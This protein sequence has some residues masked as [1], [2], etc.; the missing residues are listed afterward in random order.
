MSGSLDTPIPEKVT[1]PV[2]GMT[3]AS[4][5]ARIEKVL[6]RTP[7]VTSATV[8][9]ATGKATVQ[10]NVQWKTVFAAVER[11]GYQPVDPRPQPAQSRDDGRAR[12]Q[13]HL[14][15]LR[16]H[17]IVAAVLS[18]PVMVIS[19]LDLTFSGSAWLQLALTTPVLFWSG[20]SFCGGRETRETGCFQHGYPHRDGLGIGLRLLPLPAVAGPADALF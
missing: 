20:R 3:C 16:R 15:T 14:A 7:G 6:S 5:S 12:E 2:E 18:L 13:S 4:C 10:G 11:A 9:Y 1:F 19:M 17:L 8:N